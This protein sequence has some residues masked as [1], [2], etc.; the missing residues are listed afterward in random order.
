MAYAKIFINLDTRGGLQEH[1]TIQWR[2]TSQKQMIE[3]EGIPYQCRR[4][5]KVGHLF[6]DFP[7]NRKNKSTT[8][9]M[10]AEMTRDIPNRL[11]KEVNLVKNNMATKDT[12]GA[13]IDSGID[14][15]IEAINP[16]SSSPPTS[17]SS[18]KDDITPSGMSS[19]SCSLFT[20]TSGITA[21][22]ASHIN[23]IASYPHISP[24]FSSYTSPLEQSSLGT[25]RRALSTSLHCSL[26]LPPLIIAPYHPS[27]TSSSLPP[28]SRPSPSVS[29]RFSL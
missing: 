5:H 18:A 14:K 1:I 25:P 15:G 8:Q 28:M 19:T 9:N 12:R 4:C 6:I 17:T 13:F 27:L 29:P 11:K 7:L 24:S 23:D 10:E 2:N 16:P 22:I 26:P 21:T 3:Y 20:P